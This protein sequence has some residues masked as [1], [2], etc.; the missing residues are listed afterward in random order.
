MRREEAAEGSAVETMVESRAAS[1]R[2]S[3]SPLNAMSTRRCDGSCAVSSAI[4]GGV[5]VIVMR[6]LLGRVCA[7]G[8]GV[9]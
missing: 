2:A 8:T 7:V 6:M 5:E 1:R 3:K 4:V 9:E